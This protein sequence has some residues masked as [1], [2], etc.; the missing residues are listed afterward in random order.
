MARVV[1]IGSKLELTA[2]ATGCLTRKELCAAFARVNPNTQLTLQNSYN[3]IRGRS[4]PRSFSLYEDWAA[5]LRLP[6]G[7]HFIMSSSLEEFARVL[8]ERFDLPQ[9]ILT[10]LGVEARLRLSSSELQG[11]DGG[12]WHNRALLEGSF[13]AFSLAWSPTQRDRL[14]IGSARIGSRNGVFTLRYFEQILG[15]HVPFEGTCS[16]DGRTAQAVLRCDANEALFFMTL[17]LPPVPGNLAAGLFA[18]NAVYDPDSQ[19]TASAILFVRNH[20]L[21]EEDLRKLLGYDA[22]EP[23]ALAR[24]L[25]ALGYASSGELEAE[26]ALLKLLKGSADKALLKLDRAALIHVAALLD[27]RRLL[28]LEK[29]G[30]MQE[31]Q[32][33]AAR[34]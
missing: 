23:A 13:L 15:D 20:G 10:P 7:P 16:L 19:P 8:G 22:L 26:K 14:L 33:Q 4:H 30:R 2:T 6:E 24:C 28:T 5:V 12:P 17:H 29:D 31:R 27:K 21:E 34:L 32:A 18:G 11:N 3:W 1:A 25:D 9:A